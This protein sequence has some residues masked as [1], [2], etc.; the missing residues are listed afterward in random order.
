M[1]VGVG[2]LF[3]AGVGLS[4]GFKREERREAG[5]RFESNEALVLVVGPPGLSQSK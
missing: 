2:A 1:A 4:W 3:G 5:V